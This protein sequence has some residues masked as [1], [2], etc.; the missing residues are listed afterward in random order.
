MKRSKIQ[1]KKGTVAKK[2]KRETGEYGKWYNNSTF[3]EK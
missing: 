3:G 2:Q 1:M